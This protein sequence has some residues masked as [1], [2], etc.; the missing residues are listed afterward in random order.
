MSRI[1]GG[2]FD[3]SVIDALQARQNLLNKNYRDDKELVFLNSNH[4]WIKLTSCVNTKEGGD[5]LAKDNVLMG[6]T[7]FNSSVRQGFRPGQNESSYEINTEFGFVPMPGID[8]IS[9]ETK[10]VYGSLKAATVE[11]K[12]NSP[13]QLSKLEQLYLRP[14][15]NILLEW[16]NTVYL[17]GNDL[18]DVKT[19]PE[20]ITFGSKVKDVYDRISK[21]R[22]DSKYNYDALFG[23]IKNFQWA[24]AENGEYDCKVD[25]IGRGELIESLQTLFYSGVNSEDQEEEGDREQIG[26][27]LQQFLNEIINDYKEG[28]FEPIKSKKVANQIK[29]NLGRSVKIHS[30][31]VDTAP[32]NNR[33]F[34]MPLSDI[35]EA[36]NVCLMVK[37][38]DEKEPI[39]KFNTENN[40]E[41]AQPFV[42][43]S[44]HRIVD[45]AVGYIPSNNSFKFQ[46]KDGVTGILDIYINIKFVLGILEEFADAADSE[47]TT[48]L[49]LVNRI[50]KKLQNAGGEINEFDIHF[51]DDDRMYYIVDRDKTPSRN[52]LLTL[53]AVGKGST[54]LDISLSSKLSSRIS[55]MIAI[56]ARVNQSDAGD[57]LLGMQK[58]NEGLEDRFMSKKYITVEED[59]EEDKKKRKKTLEEFIKDIEKGEDTYIENKKSVKNMLATNLS[60]ANAKI[61]Q[62]NKDKEVPGL[63]PLELVITL[64]GMSG[65]KVGQGFLIDETIL[66]E[67]YRGVVAFIITGLA[68]E[69]EN[70]LWQTEITSQMFILPPS[71]GTAEG[72]EGAF[73][74]VF[75]QGNFIDI[76][77]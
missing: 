15:F 28:E 26:T 43:Y 29:S 18:S 65:F 67:K 76:G 3:K 61:R 47:K 73:G 31:Y 45:P 55:A 53:E 11:F 35:L 42:T 20:D 64:K 36:I 33:F 60:E 24:Y 34:Y 69:F 25:M 39:V 19:I 70:N 8:S 72:G 46:S 10:N 41:K 40:V 9:V 56:S 54:F 44:Q 63:I 37:Y 30:H 7:L 27:A 68:Q 71:T 51:D 58:W 4:S 74:G 23:V 16:G 6:G 57:Q 62:R 5:K 38:G 75:D 48:V 49:Q 52:D 2:P 1:F 21:L 59:T 12:A 14:G 32:P 22:K 77:G 17:D 50:L 66:P 13:E